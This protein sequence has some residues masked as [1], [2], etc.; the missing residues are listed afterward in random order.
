MAKDLVPPPADLSTHVP[1]HTDGQIF[2]FITN[3]F[4]GTAMPSF[5]NALT[6]QQRWDLVNYL[7]TLATPA[8]V[9]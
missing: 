6:D 4:P 5:A 7:R 2:Y 1:L 3:G 8:A 9:Q